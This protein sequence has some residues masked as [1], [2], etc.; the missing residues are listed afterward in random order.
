MRP[1]QD[2]AACQSPHWVKN[3]ADNIMK[4]FLFFGFFFFF[5]EIGF[6]VSCKLSSYRKIIMSSAAEFAQRVI[7]AGFQVGPTFP[8]FF[9]LL[10]LFF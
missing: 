7:K 6:D 9:Y 5:E 2:K 1:M 10:L 8:Y 3:S 4:Y